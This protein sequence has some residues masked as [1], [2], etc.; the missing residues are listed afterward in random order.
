MSDLPQFLRDLLASPPR[1][2]DG[3]HSWIFKVCRQLHAHRS[4]KDMFNLLKVTLE[5]C[6]RTVP[7]LEISEAIRNSKPVAWHPKKDGEP[8]FTPP[9]PR[10]LE[11]D[12]NAIDAIVRSGAEVCDVLAKSPVRFDDDESHAEEIAD[13][14]FPGNPLLCCGMSEYK[15]A[16]RRREVW[17]KRGLSNLPFIVPNPMLDFVGITQKGKPSGHSKSATACRV[18]Q[19][20]EFDFA[21]KCRNGKKDSVFAPI[22]RSWKADGIS[23]ADACA[24]LILHL[25]VILPT[26][27]V[28]CS[29]GGKSL[30]AW[31]RVFELHADAQWKFMNYAVS[32]GADHATWLKSQFV[33]IPDGLRDTGVRQ[34]AFYLDP[35]EA[36]QCPR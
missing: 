6:G 22:V 23:I 10:W 1:A 20:V 12:L 28:V 26:L 27:V 25:H 24:A 32:R 34:T 17:R 18:Y 21:E 30:H 14:I 31:F 5:D 7:D 35:K 4:E 9:H 2:G 33:R 16:T 15:F 19:G 8:V 3:I 13:V 36:V 29:S 11:P